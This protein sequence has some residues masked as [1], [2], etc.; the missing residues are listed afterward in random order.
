MDFDFFV[1][2]LDIVLVETEDIVAV[3]TVDWEDKINVDS[4]L[5][6]LLTIDALVCDLKQ[7]IFFNTAVQGLHRFLQY[8]HERRDHT[9]F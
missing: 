2:I 8:P 1:A 6:L 7:G 9:I 4:V 3:G 5:L